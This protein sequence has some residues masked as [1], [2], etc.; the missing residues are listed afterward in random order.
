MNIID[1]INNDL[2]FDLSK[3]I[4]KKLRL[5]KEEGKE[6]VPLMHFLFMLI[7]ILI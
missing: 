5:D 3:M 6:G 1:E 2:F 4:N 7:P